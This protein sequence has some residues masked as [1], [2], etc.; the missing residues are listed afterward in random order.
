VSDF[1]AVPRRQRVLLSVFFAV[2]V[3]LGATIGYAVLRGQ[4]D[5][6]KQAVLAFTAAVLSTLVVEEIMP[7][8]HRGEEARLAALVFVGAFAL[9][10]VLSVYLS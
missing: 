5:I 1:F 7:E 4:P 9:F 10:T 3:L 6:W 2:P 8:A